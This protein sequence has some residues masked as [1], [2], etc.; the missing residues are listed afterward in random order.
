MCRGTTDLL[1]RSK[2]RGSSQNQWTIPGGMPTQENASPWVN[3]EW[4]NEQ[5]KQSR[6]PPQGLA[7]H[8]F[9]VRRL[10]QA[11]LLASD[12][13]AEV[14]LTVCDCKRRNNFFSLLLW[15][16]C[17]ECCDRIRVEQII[18]SI[19]C[20]VR[21]EFLGKVNYIPRSIPPGVTVSTQSCSRSH[22]SVRSP[23]QGFHTSYFKFLHCYFH[24]GCCDVVMRCW[25]CHSSVYFNSQWFLRQD[26]HFSKSRSFCFRAV[27]IWWIQPKRFVTKSV[28]WTI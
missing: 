9:P 6:L 22:R 23:F 26:E 20:L 21:F 13:P 25:P 18:N 3:L 12:K 19:L 4:S 11:G 14:E 5:L 2:F 8:V 28:H 7:L 27:Q 10:T 1:R 15:P 24:M 16:Y 17:G